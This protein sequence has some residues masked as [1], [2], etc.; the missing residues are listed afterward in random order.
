MVTLNSCVLELSMEGIGVRSAPLRAAAALAI[1]TS[2]FAA[3]GSQAPAVSA[4]SGMKRTPQ[5]KCRGAEQSWHEAPMICPIDYRE[6]C[7]GK[8]LEIQ[9]VDRLRDH[10]SPPQF[11]F[12]RVQAF[13]CTFHASLPVARAA[14]AGAT[15]PP[16][17]PQPRLPPPATTAATQSPLPL[18][19]QRLR[20]SCC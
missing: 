7:F 8:E 12:L 14:A 10:E 18:S 4:S 19:M 9:K 5:T 13:I 6:H 11:S 3:C 16:L 20:S 15:A 1:W 17:H 2:T